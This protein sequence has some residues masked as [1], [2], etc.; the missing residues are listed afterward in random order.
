MR[1]ILWLS[2]RLSLVLLLAVSFGSRALAEEATVWIGT[3][4]PQGGQSKGIYRATFDPATGNLTTPELAAE[5]ASPGF[6]TVH[7]NGRRLYSVCELPNKQGPGVAA[8]EISENGR[9]LRL[10]NM[11]PIGDGGAAHL[12][13]D[14]SGRCLFT[15]QYGGGSVAVLP[16]DADGRIQ[17]RSDLAEHEGSGP[18]E[19]RQKGPHPHWVGVDAANR[20]LFVPDLGIDRVMIYR[21][22]LDEGKIERHG[23]G[24]C[25]AG[26]GPRH[27][28]FHP[29]GRFAYVLN[30]LQMAVTAFAYDAE[31]GTLTPMQTI[32]T[33]PEELQ[34]VPSKASEIRIHPSGRFVYAA[35]RGHDSIAVFQVDPDSGKLTFVEREAIRGSW[36]RNFNLDPTGQWLLAAGRD[37]NTLAVFRIDPATGGLVFSGK[38]VY[39]PTPIC[40]EF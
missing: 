10:L 39:C 34:E 13:V 25:P 28:K 38:S 35:N 32:S 12:A 14:R 4:T 36:P 24:V 40:V 23:A 20:F 18:N 15:A 8:F 30:E 17:P 9:S 26:G 21:M 3:I 7:P 29:N 37:S 2:V 31:A 27:L 22:N 33:L 11:Q 6:V 19:A 1:S 5:I 16:L